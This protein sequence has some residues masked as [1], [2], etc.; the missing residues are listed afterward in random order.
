MRLL[1]PFIWTDSIYAY[2]PLDTG[3]FEIG[4]PRPSPFCS[5]MCELTKDTAINGMSYGD[6]ISADTAGHYQGIIHITNVDSN[7]IA[8]TFYTN[9]LS[10]A[11]TLPITSGYFVYSFHKKVQ[12]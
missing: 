9:V 6:F 7:Y 12:P 4:N 5:Y 1:L 10:G 11:I 2:H 8:G 3:Y